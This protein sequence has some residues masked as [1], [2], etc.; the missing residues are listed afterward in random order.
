[1][2]PSPRR[3]GYMPASV[4]YGQRLDAQLDQLRADGCTRLYLIFARKSASDGPSV[5]PFGPLPPR[6]RG[7]ILRGASQV[8]SRISFS[9]HLIECEIELE[10]VD[11]LLAED[12]EKSVLGRLGDE[13]ADLIRRQVA[14]LC[15]PRH[16]ELGGGGRN[17][18]IEA[19]RRGS[20]EVDRDRCGWVFRLE[21]L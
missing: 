12:A 4:T 11:P 1:M 9:V 7:K 21:L 20:D 2:T 8:S 15:H 3:L 17:V 16:L 6:N 5:Y 14:S 18:R 13:G 10:H 19:A